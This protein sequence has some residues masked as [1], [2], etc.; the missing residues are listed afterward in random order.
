[1][2]DEGAKRALSDKGSSLLAVGVSAV[3][4]SFSAGDSVDIKDCAGYLFARGLVS[5]D[6][7]EVEL[8]LG[9]S[10]EELARNRILADLA[11]RALIHR[12]D[13][14]IFE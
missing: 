10:R 4:G 7:D 9:R 13:L 3:E 8:A 1:M 2:V 14:V 6:R 5:A 12:D 11:D